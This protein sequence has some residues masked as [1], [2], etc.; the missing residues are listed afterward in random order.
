[1]NESFKGKKNSTKSV[2]SATITQKSF[3]SL[4]QLKADGGMLKTERKLNDYKQL[5]EPITDDESVELNSNNQVKS[6]SKQ[7]S[8]ETQ[9]SG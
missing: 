8:D 5:T 6:A 4:L 9:Q 2:L 1:M 7:H 3:D